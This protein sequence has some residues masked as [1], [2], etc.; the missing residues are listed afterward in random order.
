MTEETPSLRSIAWQ[1]YQ[2]K[3]ATSAD[4]THNPITKSEEVKQKY[5]NLMNES[6]AEA[7]AFLA[8]EIVLVD[9]K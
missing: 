9:D 2:K 3:I 8:E 7:A 5:V 1:L 4:F 6:W